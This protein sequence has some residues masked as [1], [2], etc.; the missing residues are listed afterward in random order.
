[1][2]LKVTLLASQDDGSQKSLGEVIWDEENGVQFVGMTERTEAF[3]KRGVSP[4]GHV[5]DVL[6][7][8]DGK[9]YLEAL[10]YAF[11]GSR[12]RATAPKKIAQECE[13]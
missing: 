5:K 9:A 12:F 8:E 2:A 3:L 13:E 10:H 7:P 11:S 4:T 6:R 1:M